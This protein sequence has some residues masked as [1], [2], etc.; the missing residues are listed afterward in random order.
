MNTGAGVSSERNGTL[1][2]VGVVIANFLPDWAR[3]LISPAVLREY[4]SSRFS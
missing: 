2:P 4:N 1:Q 3:E